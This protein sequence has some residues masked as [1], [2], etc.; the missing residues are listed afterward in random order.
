MYRNTTTRDAHRARLRR[1]EPPCALCGK[2]IDYSL[3][4]PH[5]HCYVVDHIIPLAAGGVDSLDNK[6]PAHRICNSKKSDRTAP[7]PDL[8]TLRRSGS[9]MR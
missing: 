6:Q 8:T 1:G 2:G 3:V 5:P 9:L 7:S 4:F